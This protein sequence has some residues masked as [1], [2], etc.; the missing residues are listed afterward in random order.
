MTNLPMV[1]DALNDRRWLSRECISHLLNKSE[2]RIAFGIIRRFGYTYSAGGFIPTRTIKSER[3][4]QSIQNA[5][6][7]VAV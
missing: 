5:I 1:V 7:R 6:D 2:R 4:A 3:L